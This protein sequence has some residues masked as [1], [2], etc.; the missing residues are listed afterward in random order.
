MDDEAPSKLNEITNISELKVAAV[1]AFFTAVAAISVAI[2]LFMFR[3]TQD[4]PFAANLHMAKI[5]ACADA[6]TYLS[7]SLTERMN[8][9]ILLN[10]S[11]A[12]G[13]TK[14]I[15]ARA[16]AGQLGEG[17]SLK[18]RSNLV[19]LELLFPE[20]TELTEF[21]Q[22][23]NVFESSYDRHM[24]FI[25]IGLGHGFSLQNVDDASAVEWDVSK[26]E[27]IY[28]SLVETGTHDGLVLTADRMTKTFNELR[29]G[30]NH[31]VEMC[32]TSTKAPDL[33]LHP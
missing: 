22:K 4:D 13:K 10:G 12:E 29:I 7:H 20:R 26:T 16:Y 17:H 2:Q 6:V 25:D 27:I 30:L 24:F 1:S 5:D 21:I 11:E 19:R 23:L 9:V 15:L 14:I 32:G 3:E 31:I 8:G 18:L 28:E 33:N